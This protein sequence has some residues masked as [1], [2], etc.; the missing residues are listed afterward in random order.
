M[1]RGGQCGHSMKRR[2]LVLWRWRRYEGGMNVLL[3][4]LLSALFATSPSTQ[5]APRPTQANQDQGDWSIWAPAIVNA[6]VAVR[7]KIP[8]LDQVVIVP[9][10]ATLLDELSQWSVEGHW[11]I[12][13]DGEVLNDQ[14]IRR[15]KPQRVLQRAAV[16]QPTDR[17]AVE[18]AVGAAW[19]TDAAAVHGVAAAHFG[20]A[21][22]GL[23][24]TSDRDGGRA[25]AALLAAGRGQM[26]GWVEGDYGR[27]GKRLTTQQGAKLKAAVEGAC[28][29]TGGTWQSLGDDID[30]ITIC[31]DLGSRI[32]GGPA[33]AA[34]NQANPA[35]IAVTDVLGRTSTGKRWAFTGWIFGTPAQ[36]AYAANCSLFLPRTKV[37]L[38]DTYPNTQ[39]WMNWKLE[40][41]ASL[42]RK[43]GYEVTLVDP[44][45]FN[46]LLAAGRDGLEA[47]LAF[48]VSKGNADFFRLANGDDADAAQVPMLR[49]PAA[50]YMVHSWSLRAPYDAR[51]VGGRWLANG[52]YA[53]IGSSQEPQLQAFVPAKLL[54]GRIAQGIPW[55]IA[56]R[57][58]PGEAGQF[59]QPWR[60][61]TIGD[62]L[63]IAP[64]P[65]A[66]NRNKIAPPS[67]L[68]EGYTDVAKQAAIALREASQAHS[69][70]AFAKAITLAA[71]AGRYNIAVQTFDYA[72]GVH[73]AGAACGAAVLASAV[74]E[75]KAKMAIDA[76][77]RMVDFDRYQAD[78]IWSMGATRLDTF[79][80]PQLV[81]L[82][83]QTID[84]NASAGRV[85]VLANH[86]RRTQGPM[87]ANALIQRWLDKAKSQRQKRALK[88]L[89]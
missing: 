87:A 85:R 77:S 83:E 75:G 37:W 18:A 6:S 61:N 3:C 68:A 38:A 64:P 82:L 89:L 84:P 65:G 45:N 48:V 81:G 34:D 7:T 20:T 14:F 32:E 52:A 71:R 2:W 44:L 30:T 11:P 12:L 51:T 69:D 8:V 67:A 62:P 63:M 76:A 41:P 42:L 33:T 1:V 70:A 88:N 35:A 59:S 13:I 39:P 54:V 50:V 16:S 80:N 78:L 60:I 57:Y 58:W 15:F 47:D 74:F 4:S 19:G 49:T 56:G 79:K 31:R 46:E 55:L 24:L 23:V 29:A 25:A 26:L 40:T 28:T 17:A 10:L 21:S 36:T 27:S 86:L 9:N 5:T 22:P 53:A 43:A 73:S 66:A 72:L